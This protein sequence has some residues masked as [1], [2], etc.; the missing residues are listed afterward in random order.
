IARAPVVA[1]NL[2]L[3]QTL[4][5]LVGRDDLP[6]DLQRRVDRI[7][8]RAAYVQMHFA[9]SG[10]PTFEGQ[11]EFLNEGTHMATLGLFGGPEDLQRDFEGACRGEVPEDPSMGFQLPSLFD[12]DL[13]PPGHHA[14]SA[15]GMYFPVEAPREQHGHLKTLMGEKIIDKMCRLA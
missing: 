6:I 8:H 7:D 1:S 5:K 2:D 3:D 4:I 9:L 10:T 13:A 12:P 15:Y 14:A 11:Y